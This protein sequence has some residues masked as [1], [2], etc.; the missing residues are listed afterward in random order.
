[1]A[2]GRHR[3]EETEEFVIEKTVGKAKKQGRRSE[4]M[5]AYP[6]SSEANASGGP[7]RVICVGLRCETSP[8]S[9]P[10]EFR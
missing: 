3:Q 8:I 10:S 6:V 5:T 1:M 2:Y 9:V 4:R 7:A